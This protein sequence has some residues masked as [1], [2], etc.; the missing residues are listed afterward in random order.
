MEKEFLISAGHAL[1]GER[2]QTSLARDLGLSD[3]RRIRQWLAD[4]RPI[5]DG[6]RGD[7]ISLL[8]KRKML[9]DSTLF[10]ILD[11]VPKG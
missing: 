1:Y 11:E 7:L 5:P 10:Q 2:W 8:S 9:I 6:L 4:E 3:A